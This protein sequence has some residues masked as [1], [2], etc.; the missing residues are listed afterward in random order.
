MR[1]F[2][3][4][5]LS[6]VFLVNEAIA[7]G[8]A[9]DRDWRTA[10]TQHFRVHFEARHRLLA[11]KVARLSE[12][13]HPRV[14]AW[15]RWDPRE[16][17]EVVVADFMDQA[18]GLATPMPFNQL[19]V[20]V[21][22]PDEGEL[23]QNDDWLHMVLLHEF[24]HIVHL[25][26]ARADPLALRGVFGRFPL[27]FP[28]IFQPNW[29]IEG[30]ATYGESRPTQKIGRLRNSHFEALMRVEAARGFLSLREINAD[31]RGLP[32]NRAYLYGAY[33]F[34]FLARRYGEQAIP[35][36]IETYSDNLLPFRVYSNPQSVTG[37]A[38][39][40]LWDLFIGD[41]QQSFGAAP[42]TAPGK[43]GLGQQL[44]IAP[45]L[46]HL[47]QGPDGLLYALRY[48][49]ITRPELIRRN[50]EGKLETIAHP[51]GKA[52]F[53]VGSRGEILL[54]QPEV[55]GEH[56][57][58]N[59]LFVSTP[60]APALRRFTER[61]RWREAVWW[62]DAIDS[63]ETPS[64]AANRGFVGLRVDADGHTGLWQLDRTGHPEHLL[65]RAELDENLLGLT[66]HPNGRQLAFVSRSGEQ[67]RIVEWSPAGTRILISD[68]SIK[69]SLRYD[70]TGH[71]LYVGDE[72]GAPNLWHLETRDGLWTKRRLTDVNTAVTGLAVGPAGIQVRA[73]VPEGE[74]IFAVKPLDLPVQILTPQALTPLDADRHR[75]DVD[76][77]QQRTA[78]GEKPPQ[79]LSPD[80]PYEALPTLRPRAWLPVL[81]VADG[82]KI[83][84]AQI[85]GADVLG[86]HQYTAMPMIELSQGE[87]LVELSYLYDQRFS[88]TAARRMLIAKSDNGRVIRSYDIEENVEAV[89]LL[90]YTRRTQRI[91]GGLGVSLERNTQYFVGQGKLSW[92]DERVIS[93]IVGADSRSV[94]WR[95][96]GPSEGG[97]VEWQFT[98]GAPGSDH[99]GAAH[100]GQVMGFIPFGN[101]VLAGRLR[102]GAGEENAEPFSVGG[103]EGVGLQTI[104]RVNQRQF[105][106]RGYD[107]Q[108]Q[109]GQRMKLGTVEWRIPLDD[110][111]QHFMVPPV[112]LNRLSTTLFFESARAWT[113]SN[114]PAKTN[115]LR[116]RGIE[117][118][119]ELRLGYLLALEMRL[120]YAEALDGAKD[121]RAYLTLG[122]AF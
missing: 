96:E 65:Y 2:F 103:I 36:F 13:I 63:A 100:H 42:Q 28:N 71:L 114:I 22:P 33:F 121:K 19:Y 12:Q 66:A 72:G 25:D 35:R 67:W 75:P 26:K 8:P 109:S 74:A 80:L 45:D 57:Y 38:M 83:V 10:E 17:T 9:T 106:L 115:A 102:Y 23:L 76:G 113:P 53:E 11:D 98:R 73:L 49:G 91:Y 108:T 27:L 20:F 116:A 94:Q 15:L 89:A 59:E 68:A 3:L 111:D 78:I 97:K 120:G 112:G 82:A 84:G 1:V 87:P 29:L 119:G 48:D 101:T 70:P 90:P 60:E 34:D 61:G 43:D 55:I 64:P 69:H 52:R 30:L 107:S 62:G 40:T 118:F 6:L 39:D 58:Q 5:C 105:G 31:G 122:R 95:S 81:Q 88:L 7:I 41:L 85:F 99:P 32:L 16:K 14:T 37:V 93:L 104:P 46:G 24:I 50:A 44:L 47:T 4:V 21:A 18:N 92:Y 51:S 79:S 117:L 77:H 86:H 110:V 54:T 56:D